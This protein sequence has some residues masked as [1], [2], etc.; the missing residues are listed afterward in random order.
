MGASAGTLISPL[1]DREELVLFGSYLVEASGSLD[2]SG[3][4]ETFDF[5]SIDLAGSS[6]LAT[7]GTLASSFF[8]GATGSLL[9]VAAS[10][11]LIGT[12][13]GFLTSSFLTGAGS[14]FFSGTGSGFLTGT[15]SGFLTSSLFGTTGSTF[16]VSSFLTG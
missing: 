3:R 7:G 15:G 6:F 5:V 14:G 13:S 9:A 11:F 12:G 4:A 10:G 16:F 2:E 1:V 8:T